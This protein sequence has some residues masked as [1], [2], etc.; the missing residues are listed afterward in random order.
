MEE[1]LIQGYIPQN[2]EVDPKKIGKE[3]YPNFLDYALKNYQQLFFDGTTYTT[4]NGYNLYLTFLQGSVTV[5]LGLGQVFINLNGT[6]PIRIFSSRNQNTVTGTSNSE[7]NFNPPIILK[8]LD[9]LSFT[10]WDRVNG[11]G[12][13]IPQQL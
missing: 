8:P 9:T 10:G 6:A 2:L 12:I 11:S 3:L 7:I 5:Q 1:Q 13:L 4:P